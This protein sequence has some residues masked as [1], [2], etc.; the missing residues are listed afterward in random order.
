MVELGISPGFTRK[1][2]SSLNNK[3]Q[4]CENEHPFENYRETD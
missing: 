2:W 1:V 4:A 3:D